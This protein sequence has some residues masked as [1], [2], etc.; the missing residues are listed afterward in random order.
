MPEE[1]PLWEFPGESLSAEAAKREIE[2]AEEAPTPSP[3]FYEVV[4]SLTPE[5]E[6]TEL[7]TEEQAEAQLLAYLYSLERGTGVIPE[8]H[9]DRAADDYS[10]ARQEVLGRRRSKSG[11]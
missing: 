4:V 9:P 8:Y 10:R 3:F 7:S 6:P 11:L 1:A 2:L 5:G